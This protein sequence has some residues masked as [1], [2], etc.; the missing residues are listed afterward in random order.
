MP[1]LLL[2]LILLLASCAPVVETTYRY[3]PPES[4]EGQRCVAACAAERAT[5]SQSCDRRE[6]LCLTDADSRALR[7]YRIDTDDFGNARRP[8]S[9]SVFDYMD[10]YRSLCRMEGCRNACG[11]TYRACYERCGG[12]VTATRTCTANCGG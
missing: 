12:R 6:K 11:D 7:D 3:A 4:A 1:A 5:C 8:S 9:R 10:R 2:A